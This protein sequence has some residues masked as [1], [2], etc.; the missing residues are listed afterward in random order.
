MKKWIRLFLSAAAAG[1]AIGIGGCISLALDNAIVGALFFALGLLT[2]V[3]RGLA[4]YTGRVGYAVCNPPAYWGELGVIWLGNFAGA[5]L[6]GWLYSLTANAKI[7]KALTVSMASIDPVSA[8]AA[9][10]AGLFVLAFFCGVLMFIAVNGY[11]TMAD[12]F[13][14]YL[15]VVLPVAVFILCGFKH[16]VANMA[17]FAHAAVYFKAGVPIPLLSLL[18]VTAGNSL[19][20]IVSA[21]IDLKIVNRPDSK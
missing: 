1:F 2:V 13:G 4:L 15:I 16:C 21:W 5:T 8:G 12:S 10:I 6:C 19:G 11:K 3:T 20:S 14:R 17:Y 18:I 9:G 7:D